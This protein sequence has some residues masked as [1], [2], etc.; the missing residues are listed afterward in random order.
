M[1]AMSEQWAGNDCCETPCLP[2]LVRRVA[3][4]GEEGKSRRMLVESQPARGALFAG[5]HLSAVLTA[6]RL[7]SSDA[8]NLRV[9][10][11]ALIALGAFATL[12]TN[13]SVKL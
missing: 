6:M 13:V 12:A 1:Q 9:M 5:R 2:M 8:P 11:N 4:S 10:F 3:P 7:F